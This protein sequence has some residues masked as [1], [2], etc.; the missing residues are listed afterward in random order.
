MRLRKLPRK[1]HKRNK[2]ILRSA[3][4][5]M[6]AKLIKTFKNLSL[7]SLNLKTTK[8]K[9]ALP[10]RRKK[11]RIRARTTLKSP[12]SWN[13][14]TSSRS[15]S[16]NKR[17]RNAKKNGFS[18]SRSN[19]RKRSHL[20]PGMMSASSPDQMKKPYRD[21]KSSFFNRRRPLKQRKSLLAFWLVRLLLRRSSQLKKFR[22]KMKIKIN[23]LLL[24]KKVR[25][26]NTP[27]LRS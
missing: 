8:K 13:R 15:A 5:L 14:S 18:K 26:V 22:E 4:H 25:V 16:F 17:K 1:Q 27:T 23:S 12:L 9:K 24:K 3:H 19:S 6:N 20:S 7:K 10:K 21:V 2:R 11:R